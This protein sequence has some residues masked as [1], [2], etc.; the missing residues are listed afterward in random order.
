MST[1]WEQRTAR[2]HEA[3]DIVSAQVHCSQ[4]EALTLLRDRAA[5]RESD[6]EDIAL[7]VAGGRSTF[8]EKNSRVSV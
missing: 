7:A 6:L 2:V 5:E 3:T 8:A 1:W 4:S